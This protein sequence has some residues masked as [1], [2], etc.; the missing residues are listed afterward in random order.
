MIVGIIIALFAAFFAVIAAWWAWQRDQERLIVQK[1][2]YRWDTAT[3]GKVLEKDQFGPTFGILIRNRS[4]FS[5]HVSSVGFQINGEVIELE[6]PLFPATMKKNPDPSS[7]FPYIAGESDPR[8]IP[9][10]ASTQVSVTDA[11]RPRIATALL[12]AS[13]RHDVSIEQLL[14]SPKVAA[15]VVTETGKQFT[16]MPFLKRVKR[17]LKRHSPP[18]V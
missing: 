16:S 10:Q 18:R 1:L 13:E 12:K 5:V 6:G 4:L 2:L 17:R 14:I 3:G 8:E 15:I 9:S 7:K 11:D